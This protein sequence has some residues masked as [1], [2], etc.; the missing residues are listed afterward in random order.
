MEAH[1]RWRACSVRFNTVQDI[2][3]ERAETLRN[4]D[5]YPD[6]LVLLYIGGRDYEG[7]DEA[8]VPCAKPSCAHWSAPRRRDLIIADAMGGD[9][10]RVAAA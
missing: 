4:E 5:I 8:A 6:V 3:T 2:I 9:F 7:A 10:G 1:F